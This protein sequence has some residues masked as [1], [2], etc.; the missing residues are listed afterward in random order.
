M[1]KLWESRRAAAKVFPELRI[2]DAILK[3]LG[4]DGMSTDEEEIVDG[5]IVYRI[6]KKPWRAPE[7]TPWIR[8]F[9]VAYRMDRL[10]PFTRSQGS[11]PR[12]RRPT[13]R[14]SQSS[15]VVSGLPRRAY[16]Q[17]WLEG[18]SLFQRQRLDIS[19]EDHVFQHTPEAQL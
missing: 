19:D 15:K 10:D 1:M 4:P 5:A 18:L 12:V 7:V 17:E 3:V 2:H 11:V 6:L 8:V 13:E 9:D 16:N 14:V